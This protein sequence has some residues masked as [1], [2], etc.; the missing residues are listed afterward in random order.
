M[1]RKKIWNRLSSSTF[2]YATFSTISKS[3]PVLIKKRP[4]LTFVYRVLTNF[5]KVG[6]DIYNIQ[7][8]SLALEVYTKTTKVG[9]QPTFQQKTEKVTNS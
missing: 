3:A 4:R 9:V 1:K 8:F 6:S 2:N 7:K 5:L